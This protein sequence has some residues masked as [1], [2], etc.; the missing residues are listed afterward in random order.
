MTWT[1]DVWNLDNSYRFI[2]SIS[3]ITTLYCAQYYTVTPVNSSPP[4]ATYMC[5]WTGPSLAHVMACRLFGATPL[6]EPRLTY[7]QLDS[8]EQISVKFESELYHFHWRKCIWKCRLPKW[9]PFCP[10]GDDVNMSGNTYLSPLLEFY[11]I[12]SLAPARFQSNF[13]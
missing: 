2:S 3:Q 5:Q 9:W 12:N 10:G 13:R 7:C 6:P 1:E 8:W 11:W 4:S